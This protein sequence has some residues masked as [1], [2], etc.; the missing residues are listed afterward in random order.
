MKNLFVVAAME[1]TPNPERTC[2]CSPDCMKLLEAMPGFW[3][4]RAFT[5]R[6]M[7]TD[8]CA[9]DDVEGANRHMREASRYEAIAEGGASVA[10]RIKH[11]VAA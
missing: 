9:R 5:R 10:A 11:G 7:F 8:S 2:R 6:Q 4:G 3:R 1:T